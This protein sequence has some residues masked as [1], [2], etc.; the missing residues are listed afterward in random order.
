[1][2]RSSFL[3]LT[4]AT[5][6]LLG[7]GWI[8]PVLAWKSPWAPTVKAKPVELTPLST[9]TIDAFLSLLNTEL[10]EFAS[11][12]KYCQGAM[13]DLNGDEIDDYVFILPWMGCGLN[14]DGTTAHFILSSERGRVETAVEGY[15][16]ELSDLVE[17]N[18]KIYFL[19]STFF[20]DFEK[21]QHNHWV[22]QAFTFEKN[23]TVTHANATFG[24][25]VPAATIYYNNPKF[26]RVPLTPN[27][28]KLIHEKTSYPSNTYIP[29]QRKL[30]RY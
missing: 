6:L 27:D 30:M 22:Y 5:V 12:A 28:L 10:V 7:M 13:L 23:G 16:I 26:K 1:M 19:H 11:T 29:A 14:A 21:S 20:N 9:E 24:S 8:N 2:M 25:L 15:A 3:R 17:L 4:C 18:G